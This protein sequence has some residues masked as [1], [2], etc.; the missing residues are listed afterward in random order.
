MDEMMGTGRSERQMD[1]SSI[2]RWAQIAYNRQT[3]YAENIRLNHNAH[4]S[5]SYN[6][7]LILSWLGIDFN[8]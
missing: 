8:F 2:N 7:E 6:L 3:D 5:K 1:A 4:N